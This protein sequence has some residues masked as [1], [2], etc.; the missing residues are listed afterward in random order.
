MEDLRGTLIEQRYISGNCRLRTEPVEDLSRTLDR[1]VGRQLEHG[2]LAVVRT[3]IAVD[4]NVGRQV[5]TVIDLHW[6]G[7]LDLGC[8]AVPFRLVRD[9]VVRR[10]VATGR[11]RVGGDGPLV[12]HVVEG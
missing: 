5:V 3:E 11:R 10:L 2:H 7:Q 4:R 6:R 1:R 9:D 12:T 8:G